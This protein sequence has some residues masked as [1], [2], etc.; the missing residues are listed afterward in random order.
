M[1][2]ADASVTSKLPRVVVYLEP[3]LK[4]D[5]EKL[6]KRRRRSVSNLITVLLQEEVE[7]ARRQGELL[8]EGEQG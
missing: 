7:E 3:Q 6:A 2:N 5:A 1:V 4:A 8:D